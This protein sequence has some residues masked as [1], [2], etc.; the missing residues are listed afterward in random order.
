MS[1]VHYAISVPLSVVPVAALLWLFKRLDRRRP[2]PRNAL[3]TTMALG[4]LACAPAALIEWVEHVALGDASLVGGRFVDAFVVAAF[5]EEA[6]K[7]VVVLSF[8]FRRSVFD[9][10][11]D[12]VVYTVAASL[13]FGL[14]ENFAFVA[15][16]AG[17]GTALARALTAVPMHALASGV[18][19]YFVGRA[20]FVPANAAMPLAMAGLFC[21]VAIHGAYDWAVFNRDSM[22]FIESMGVLVVAGALMAALARE[23]LRIDDAMLGRHSITG[24]MES[25]WPT[26][27]TQTIVPQAV[28]PKAE[29][30]EPS[31]QS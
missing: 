21:G 3:Y 20:R 31:K 14:L 25:S 17:F 5:T 1:P 26:E 6:L 2:V 13:G 9:E 15:T 12:G 22:W 27:V 8:P 10:V 24:F 4:A 16:D 11:I 18:M 29:P 23:A 7:L 28:L 19:G 30:I